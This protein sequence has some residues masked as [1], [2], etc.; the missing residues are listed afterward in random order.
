MSPAHDLI[1]VSMENW[2]AHWRRNQF[3]CAELTRRDPSLR[4]LFVGLPRNFSYSLSRGRLRDFDQIATYPAPG[5]DRVTVTHAPKWLPDSLGPARRINE[6]LMRRHVRR[7]AR[8]VG[9]LRPVLWLNPHH[10]VHMAGRMGESA[11][12]YDITD[13]WTTLT[14]SRRLA[15]LTR[16]QDAELCRRADATIVCSA[17]LREMKAP[18]ARHLYLIP[19]GV[20]AAHYARVL[21][22]VTAPPPAVAALPKPVFGYTGTIHPDRVDVGLVAELARAYPNGS[23]VM[24][25]PNFLSAADNERLRS[26]RNVHLPGA[27]PYADIPATMAT[28]DV[29]I[30]PHRMTPFTESLNPIK[31]WEYLAAGLP[32]VSTDVAGFRDFPDLVRLARTPAEFVAAAGAA[33]AE[34]RAKVDAR[35]AAVATHSWAGRVDEVEAVIGSCLARR[36]ATRAEPPAPVDAKGAARVA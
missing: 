12:V 34:G 28:F 4:V 31:L 16:R 7:I 33:L 3:L 10:A 36:A 5:F 6:W 18:L 20:D 1:F 9:L 25:G 11:C 35:R 8:R 32:I 15:E 17:R 22:P 13:D 29:C 24:V 26:F 19:N 2:D 14:Q 23:V 21:D 30:T 27:A